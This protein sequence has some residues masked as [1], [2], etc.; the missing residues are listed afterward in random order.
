ML[1]IN[2][3]KWGKLINVEINCQTKSSEEVNTNG[4]EM[5]FL[6]CPI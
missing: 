5:T 4:K 3:Y 1:T 2:T 6:P